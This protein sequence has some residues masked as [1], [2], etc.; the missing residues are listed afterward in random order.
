MDISQT[1]TAF[2]T[3]TATASNDVSSASAI[4][5]DFDT[6]L[7]MLTVQL[8]NQDPLNPVDSSDYAMQL[9]TFSGVEQQV[10]TNDLLNQMIAEN[11]AAGLAEMAGW[12]GNE[13]R[14]SAQGYWGGDDVTIVPD[15]SIGADDAQLLVRNA[16]G[17]E[18]A[19][20]S[21]ATDGAAFAWD[22][23][24]SDGAA[25]PYGSYRF[26]IVSYQDGAA[27]SEAPAE[28]YST[29]TEVR[30]IDGST[31][32]VLQ[33]GTVVPSSDVSALRAPDPS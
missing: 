16:A 8:E 28:V 24:G 23:K 21:V 7:T 14:V 27:I 10:Q 18:V 33:G 6:F 5:S 20:T 32:I 4:S 1:T 12:V 2:T 17:T 29:V 13:A 31:S 3:S 25:L 26:D 9:A 30:S 22:G 11:S 19:R 15:L